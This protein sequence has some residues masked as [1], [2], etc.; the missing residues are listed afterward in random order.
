MSEAFG[1]PNNAPDKRHNRFDVETIRA[2][3]PVLQQ[4]VHGHALVYLDNSA[5][6][7]K[8]HA[9]INAVRHYYEH[10]NANVHRGVH[11]LSERATD[12]YEAG[13]RAGGE[14]IGVRDANEVV[15]TRGTT[16]SINLVAQS[17][18]RP[19]LREGDEII[20]S[21]LEHHSNI[22]PWQLV[23]SATGAKIRIIPVSEAGELDMAEYHELLGPRT[24]LVAIT[25]L[26]N[27]LGTIIDV[28]KIVASAHAVGAK[29]LIDGAQA[30]PHIP[31]DV[32]EI[33]CDFYA[34]SGHKVCAPT[35]IGVLWAHRELLEAMEP[36]QGGGEMIRTVSFEGSTW[37]D[38][39]HKFEAGTPNI[40]GSVGLAA[41]VSYLRDIGM[42]V[43]Q[44]Y[45]DELLD[46]A[47][48]AICEV[49]GVRIIGTSDNKSAVLS[50]IMDDIHAHDIGTI[51][52]SQ[53][54]A[55]R[56]GHHCAMPLHERFGLSATAR[57]SFAFYNTRSDID[58][59]IKALHKTR[60]M[61]RL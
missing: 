23:A 16:E 20:I 13:R 40:A 10:D 14:L 18:A 53:G 61:F 49:P 37:N 45:E 26:S 25:H 55:I 59:L 2:D 57:A 19:R 12:G 48:Q 35:G 5:T 34:Y 31:V 1:R 39:P 9:V 15:L 47:T 27:A 8:P 54:V 46:Y 36:Y 33:G 38:V 41:A 58:A 52:D 32:G 11:T 42:E 24:K 56:V 43:I 60:E 51:V 21:T 3:F 6:S 44:E 29:V 50:F 22:V 17:W 30:A 4:Q 7:Q 28:K